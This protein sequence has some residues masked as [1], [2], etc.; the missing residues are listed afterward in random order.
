[1]V[2]CREQAAGEGSG[3]IQSYQ[4][5]LEGRFFAP[6]IKKMVYLCKQLPGAF[7]AAQN[8]FARN[9]NRDVLHGVKLQQKMSQLTPQNAASK[10]VKTV[11]CRI[12]LCQQNNHT[13][14]TFQLE[15]DVPLFGVQATSFPEGV[16]GAWEELHRKLG[17]TNGRAFYGIS[18][19]SKDGTIVYKACVEEA[20]DGEL[21]GLDCERFLLPKGEYTGETI[22]NFM[23]QLPRIGETFQALLARGDYDTT[24]ACVEQYLN[25]ADVVCMIKRKTEI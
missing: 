22:H 3:G 14:Q 10:Q 5:H 12:G 13:M 4:L 6:V 19:G 9:K 17:V 16:R 23:Q 21:A 8:C 7:E 11:K 2:V 15:K 24:S 25:D 20:F 18:H 1:M